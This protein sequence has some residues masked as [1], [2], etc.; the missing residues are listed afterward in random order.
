MMDEPKSRRS[1]P[2]IEAEIRE[3]TPQPTA[4]AR[5]TQ[6]MEEMDLGTLFD[7]H[8]PNIAH[9]LADMGIEPAGPPYGRY[10]EFGPERVDVE[11][12]I[13]VGAPVPNLRSL[14][15]AEAGE[16]A[17]SEL[18]GGPAA[19]TVHRGSYDGLSATYQ[20]LEEWITG[21]GREA[22]SG[23][24]ESYVDDPAEVAEA[25]LRTEVCWPLG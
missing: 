9:R 8:L 22:G 24:W 13:P 16:M 18:P 7:E 25:D 11:I 12:G 15:D 23:P 14:A 17:A 19:I 20:A 3:L 4:S 6:P 5:M 1:E 10:H 21:Q 2:M